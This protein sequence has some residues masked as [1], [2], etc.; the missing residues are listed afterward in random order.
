MLMG[1]GTAHPANSVYGCLQAVFEDEGYE[2]VFV[3]TVEGYPNF[4]NVIKEIKK[5]KYK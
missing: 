3:A 1:H 2:N 4:E 5:K